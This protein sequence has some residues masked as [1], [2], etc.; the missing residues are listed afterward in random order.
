MTEEVMHQ[1][2]L[3]LSQPN[4]QGHFAKGIIKNLNVSFDS[5]PS[6]RFYIDMIVVD[7]LRNWGIVFHKDL[8]THLAGIFQDKESKVI[9]SHPEGGFFTLYKEPL[10]GSLIE[11]FDEP[12]DQIICINNDIDN[13]FV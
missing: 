3:S 9:I 13:W 12:S 7:Y 1:L 11:T 6:A 5:F 10:T 8:I 4:D 2:G